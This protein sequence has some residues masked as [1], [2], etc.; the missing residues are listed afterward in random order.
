[1]IDALL[2]GYTSVVDMV[3][4][5]VHRV[6]D[7]LHMTGVG[8]YWHIMV[9]SLG[10][11]HLFFRALPVLSKLTFPRVYGQLSDEDKRS[12]TVC[13]LSL[14]HCIFDTCFV[15]AYL[16]NPAL[17]SDKMRGRNTDFEIYLSITQGYYIWDMLL[18]IRNYRSYGPMYLL[19]A[20]LGVYALL[21]LTSG[22]LQFYSLVYILPEVSSVFLNIR[23]LL[24]FAGK[25]DTLIYKLNFLLFAVSFVGI[26]FGYE[27]Y[28]S[29]LLVAKTYNGDI[30]GTYYP[31]ALFISLMGLTLTTLNI[32][33]MRQIATVTYYT[34]FKPK[35]KKPAQKSE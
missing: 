21:I 16:G 34:L 8:T 2:T 7:P 20:G 14:A 28:H 35:P 19:H 6:F 31:F 9:V 5:A 15:A 29:V 26:R 24:K 18:C 23:H 1:M 27:A 30:G 3:S 13:I 12:W 10:I 11:H 17:T 33:W 25:S 22:H 32:I 4:P